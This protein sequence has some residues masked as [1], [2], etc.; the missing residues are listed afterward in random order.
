MQRSDTAV[1]YSPGVWSLNDH[2]VSGI[3]SKSPP[4]KALYPEKD[5][6]LLLNP[7]RYYDSAFHAE[8]WRSVWTRSWTCAGLARDIPKEGDW[9][10]Y[11][12]GQESI[13]VV[14]QRD[15][16]IKALYNVCK[17]RGRLLVEA[18]FGHT[19]N[20]VCPFHAW[21]YGKDGK[22]LR[23]SDR[24][25]FEPASLC[26]DLNLRSLRCEV[27][28]GLVFVN[29]DDQ[30][31]PLLSYL[32]RLPELLQPYP[33][34]DMHLVKDVAIELPCNWK[35]A[36]EAFLEPYHAHITHSQILP[37]VDELYNQYDFF[38]N[39]HAMVVT[40]VA[41]PSPRFLD[42]A[43]VNPALAWLLQE[44]GIDPQVFEGGAHDVRRAIWQAKRQP[45]NAYGLDYSA[46]SDS[47][48]TD[49]WNPSFFPNMTINAH[50]E[51]AMI[52]RFLPH[53]SDPT[54][55]TY[56]VW[57]LIPRLRDGL[58]PPAYMGVEDDVDISGDTRPARR[59]THLD[60][61]QLGEVLEQDLGNLIRMQ[62]GVMS[63]GMGDGV[64][65][66]ELEQRIQQVHAEIDRCIARSTR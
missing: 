63:A 38:R 21:S 27:W 46:Y 17:H 36:M 58:R 37:A 45:E 57:V 15:L 25:Y 2:S 23:V 3:S 5:Q 4:L 53:A 30:A 34:A 7:R 64:R 48:L 54:R 24:E 26:G 47:Q 33:F 13:I 62:Q 19:H 60:D 39:G 20:F 56:H 31:A 51:G 61:P 59:R 66:G 12:L 55:C 16:S 52:M 50:P 9:F 22:N 44:V 11:E 35:L 42:Q 28:N 29:P 10:K 6:Y 43:S 32:D 14:R 1:P 49:D 65:L 8:E 40:P 18:D 41:L